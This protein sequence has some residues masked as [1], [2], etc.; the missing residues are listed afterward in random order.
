M[1]GAAA[2]QLAVS[3]RCETGQAKAEVEDRGETRGNEGSEE[4]I[5]ELVWTMK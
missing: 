3:R 4:Q 2:E 5:Q 1:R